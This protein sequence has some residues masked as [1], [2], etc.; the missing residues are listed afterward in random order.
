VYTVQKYI[1]GTEDFKAKLSQSRSNHKINKI[2]KIKTFSCKPQR[3]QNDLIK[4]LMMMG[5][6]L[7]WAA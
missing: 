7:N 2:M 6:V 3:K 4:E 5:T 1:G